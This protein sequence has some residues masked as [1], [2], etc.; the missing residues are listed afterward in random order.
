VIVLNT[1]CK[2]DDVLKFSGADNLLIICHKKLRPV[3]QNPA[4]N[5][6][7]IQSQWCQI[8][9]PLPK[10]GRALSSGNK[11]QPSGYLLRFANLKMAQSIYS[12]FTQLEHGD[13]FPQ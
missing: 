6:G 4:T 7:G 3:R 11:W 13:D 8:G 12:G 5:P 2:F 10:S 1:Y 9:L